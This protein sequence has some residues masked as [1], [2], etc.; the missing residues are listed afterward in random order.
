MRHIATSGTRAGVS[1]QTLLGQTA[2]LAQSTAGDVANPLARVYSSG[3]SP[4]HTRVIPWGEAV[5]RIF[6]QLHRVSKA[7]GCL[8]RLS[9][10]GASVTTMIA[11]EDVATPV[12]SGYAMEAVK[13]NDGEV[14]PDGTVRA[15]YETAVPIRDIIRLYREGTL[16]VGNIRPDHEIVGYNPD[17]S[18]KYANTSQRIVEWA[19]DLRRGRVVLGNHSWNLN[20][21]LTHF[22]VSKVEGTKNV[23]NVTMTD[24][25]IDTEIDSATRHRAIIKA[26]RDMESSG[27]SEEAINKLLDRLVSVRVYSVQSKHGGSVNIDED[28]MTTE[29][30]FTVF[31]NGGKGVNMSTTRWWWQKSAV[32]KMVRRLVDLTDHL[33]GDRENGNVDTQKTS[34]APSSWKL[35]AFNTLVEAARTYWNINLTDDAGNEDE[36]KI[37]NEAI[38]LADWFNELVRVRPEL[39]ILAQ[40][41]RPTNRRHLVSANAIAFPAYFSVASRMRELELD[42]DAEEQSGDYRRLWRL[43]HRIELPKSKPLLPGAQHQKGDTVDW[44]DFDNPLWAQRGVVSAFGKEGDVRPRISRNT[45]PTRRAVRAE[46]M[47]Q[48]GFAL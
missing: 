46:V 2:Q 40:A 45:W 4:N 31:Q 41:E 35:V 1:A 23:Y 24:G 22:T 30:I 39:G 42:P 6:D 19:S 34:V 13:S 43:D 10:E 26:V 33:G 9:P 7:A 14:L 16:L 32:E 44:F 17:G 15:V 48:L 36:E 25:V 38:W 12:S 21:D 11:P 3:C 18:P 8:T 5:H 29:E 27:A 20:P 47:R 37:E 28:A